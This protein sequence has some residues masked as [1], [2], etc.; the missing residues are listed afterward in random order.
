MRRHGNLFE[1]VVSFSALCAAATRAAAGKRKTA[2]A[3]RFLER[4]E[5]ECLAL[6]RELRARTWKPSKAAHFEIR[7]PKPRVITAV[8]FRDRVVHHALM[9]V[10]GPIF[11]RRMIGESFACREG[12]G[13]HAALAHARRMLR[14]YRYFLKLDVKSFFPSLAHDVV[15]ESIARVLKDRRVL[16]LCERIVRAEGADAR[17]IPI[18]S[19]TSQWFANLVLD[20][21]DHHVKETLRIP[22]YVRYMDDFVLFCDERE[23]L[24]RAL[25]DVRSF[26]TTTFRLELK[27]RA[28]ILAPARE[29]LPFLGFH[30]YRS[31]TRLRHENAKRSLG[32]LRGRARQLRRGE[33]DF[34][35]ALASMRSIVA[36]LEHGN[37]LG[38]RR[39]WF[40]KIDAGWPAA[41]DCLAMS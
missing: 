26:L 29:G 31:V 23:R 4:M 11:D 18:G 22:G 20:R 28:R 6:E 37:T 3:A 35:R 34:D 8:P 32:K 14:R 19:L 10:L 2:G 5:P 21:L 33:I 38:L 1:S 15:L 16:D 36:H 30:H 39:R 12:K 7:D 40:A 17:G 24:R 41:T 9:G 27:D 13:T 25:D